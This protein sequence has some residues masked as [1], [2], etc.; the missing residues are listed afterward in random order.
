V[1]YSII[2]TLVRSLNTSLTVFFVLLALF[3]LGGI[4]IHYFILALL[5]GVTTG[6]YSSV[7]NASQLLVVW[8]KHEWNRFYSW[9]PFARKSA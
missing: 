7:C 3:L 9:L 5:I 2:Q 8:E 1:N 4:T 6:T